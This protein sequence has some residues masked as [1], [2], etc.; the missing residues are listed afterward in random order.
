MS[1]DQTRASE[2]KSN[3]IDKILRERQ[4]LDRVLQD[5]FKKEV[6]VLFTD[7]CGYTAHIDKYGDISGRT[8]IQRHNDIVLTLIEEHEGKVIKT[9][10]DGVMSTFKTPLNAV[11]SSVAI[12]KRLHEYN[13]GANAEEYIYLKIGINTGN[14]LV[15]DTDVFGDTV[16]VA[17]RIQGHAG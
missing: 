14:A 12:Q 17:A 5:E 4:R 16:N 3:S 8:L 1:G 9:I 11:K 7:I 6:T 15:D 2:D 13:R 10:G